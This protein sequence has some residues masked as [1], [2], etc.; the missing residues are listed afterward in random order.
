MRLPDSELGRAGH[1]GGPPD[2]PRRRATQKLDLACR[3]GEPGIS[4]GE[5]RTEVKVASK[6]VYMSTPNYCPECGAHIQDV[7]L[8]VCVECDYEFDVSQKW[9][10]PILLVFRWVV[11]IPAGL[12]GGMLVEVVV[13]LFVGLQQW[14][15]GY[16]FDAPLGSLIA[17]GAAGWSF[18]AIGAGVAPFERKSAPAIAMAVLTILILGAAIL[19]SIV[20]EDWMTVLLCLVG[21]VGVVIA[22]ASYI[23]DPYQKW[24]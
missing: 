8:S 12:I 10:E 1:S 15:V 5:D 7:D 6:G 24:F 23:E 14:L 13:R 9:W 11:F 18:V 16:P 3:S 17:A 22:T 21:V 19:V 2:T 20:G 4:A